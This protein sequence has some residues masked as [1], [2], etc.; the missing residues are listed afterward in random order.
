[1]NV[2]FVY[3]PRPARRARVI[4]LHSSG[5]ASQWCALP[6]ALGMIAMGAVP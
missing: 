2:H 5:G 3:P 6:E 4:V 1:M